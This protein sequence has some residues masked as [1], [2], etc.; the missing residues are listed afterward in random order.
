MKARLVMIFALLTLLAFGSLSLGRQSQAG[1]NT[2]TKSAHQQQKSVSPGKE[3]GRGGKDIGKG[4]GK[5]AG[6]M[7]KGTAG[8]AGD[9]V[10][11][12]PIDAGASLGK[13]A[14]GLGKDVGV[15]TAKGA[16]KIGKGAGEGV[17]KLGG[18]IVHHGKKGYTAEL[19]AHPFSAGAW[20]PPGCVFRP[21]KVAEVSFAP[22]RT[23]GSSLGRSE[24]HAPEKL[25]E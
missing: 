15:G 22:R 11:L 10:T 5:G 23:I 14:G 12:H 13:G 1:E 16:A 18:K 6:S 3:V 19:I 17:G 20:A 24:I 9:L 4:A 7:A 2:D 21:W 8:A 25:P